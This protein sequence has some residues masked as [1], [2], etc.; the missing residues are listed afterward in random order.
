[1]NLQ[2]F[3]RQWHGF[4]FDYR[5]LAGDG[6]RIVYPKTKTRRITTLTMR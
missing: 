2:A 3:S 6:S 4:A 5:L 1:M